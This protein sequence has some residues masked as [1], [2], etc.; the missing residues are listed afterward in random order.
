M[1]GKNSLL[2]PNTGVETMQINPLRTLKGFS[3]DK[4]SCPEVALGFLLLWNFPS[5][6]TDPVNC[7]GEQHKNLVFF[8]GEKLW[9]NTLRTAPVPYIF[10][11]YM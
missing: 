8:T 11:Y 1:M 2:T 6:T 9:G 10:G 3:K 5:M 4:S 7:T